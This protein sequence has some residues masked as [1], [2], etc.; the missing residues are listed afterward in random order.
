MTIESVNVYRPSW[1]ALPARVLCWPLSLLYFLL[2]LGVRAIGILWLAIRH[3]GNPDDGAPEGV[4]RFTGATARGVEYLLFR[5]DELPAL[6]GRVRQEGETP[7]PWWEAKR[8]LKKSHVAMGSVLIFVLYVYVGLAAQ[9]GW[10]AEDY[11]AGHKTAEFA[12]P[13]ET[14]GE[15]YFLLGSDQLGRDVFALALRGTTTALWIGLFAA[16]LSSLIGMFLG[17]LAGYFGGWID[18]AIV[19]AYTTLSAIPYLLLVMAFSF[20]FKNNPA[21]SDSYNESFLKMSWGVSLGLFTIILVIGLTS[22]VSTCRI[23]RAEMIKHRDRDYV[24]AARAMGLSTPRLIFRHMLPNVFHL[25][26]ITFSLLFI[27]AIKFEVILS[28]LGL[29]LEPEEASW[30]NM[31]SKGAS[32]LL[33]ADTV[34]WQIS[35]ATVALFGIVLAVNLFADALRDALDPR[36][37]K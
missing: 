25:V 18:D 27:S 28:F 32:E 29:G 24:L 21:I 15:T 2:M 19:W 4:R 23:V 17:S 14:K 1:L 30:G 3:G 20:V 10:I 26:L 34:W 35:V 12:H 13:G 31:I 22:W 16:T 8:R 7:G 36:L 37:R 33:R 5:T 9:V 11:R 6:S